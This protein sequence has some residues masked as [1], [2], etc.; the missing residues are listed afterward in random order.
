MSNEQVNKQIQSLISGSC[1]NKSMVNDA[2]RMQE[3]TMFLIQSKELLAKSNAKQMNQEYYDSVEIKLAKAT[4]L[5]SRVVPYEAINQVD[6]ETAIEELIE[7]LKE[8]HQEVKEIKQK[9]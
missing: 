7:A 2:K 8:I 9:L 1:V 4:R 6:L 3:S 5:I